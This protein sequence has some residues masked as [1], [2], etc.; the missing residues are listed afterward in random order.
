MHENLN[1]LKARVFK[2]ARFEFFKFSNLDIKPGDGILVEWEEGPEFAEVFEIVSNE[3]SMK[4]RDARNVIRRMN[5]ED[6]KHFIRKTNLE[7]NAFDTCIKYCRKLSVPLK[8]IQVRY[9]YD[10]R[11]ATFIY[12][13][14]GRVDFRQ[15]I[16]ELARDLK[17]KIE[18]RQIGVRDEAKIVGGC[19]AC[20][21]PLCCATH[22]NSFFPVTVKMAKLQGLVL[23]PTKILGVCGRLK[24]CLYYEYSEEEQ[25]EKIIY[26]YDEDVV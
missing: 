14:D 6:R 7:I 16:K 2:I 21:Y 20:G 24:C 13:A 23:N 25:E 12:T 19:G 17:V 9:T 5:E 4:I 26:E 11:K 1:F 15:L 22:L 8:L 18:M 3:I 10:L